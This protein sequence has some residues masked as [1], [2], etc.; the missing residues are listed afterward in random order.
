M[1]KPIMAMAMAMAL[2]S[3]TIVAS[4]LAMARPGNCVG[5]HCGARGY[6]YYKHMHGQRGKV[7]MEE[8]KEF[9]DCPVMS[10]QRGDAMMGRHG[11]YWRR[12]HKGM[13]GRR[14][15]A[16]TG[17]REYTADEIRTLMEARLL[18]HSN[19]DFEVGE[20]TATKEGYTV[21]IVTRDKKTLFREIE[22]DKNGV[23]LK[24]SS[25]RGGQGPGGK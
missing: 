7:M 23:P 22:L 15:N 11:E 19:D 8:N 13:S 2:A 3:A 25:M 21:T 18:Q 17:G 12:H 6:G 14:G 10:G 4:G 16:M 24:N 1:K 5:I 20:V 9:Q